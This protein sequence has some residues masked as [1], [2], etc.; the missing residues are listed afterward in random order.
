MGW[1]NL[2]LT[3]RTVPLG[4]FELSRIDVKLATATDVSSCDWVCIGCTSLFDS[5]IC[6]NVFSILKN[7]SSRCFF[8][9]NQRFWTTKNIQMKNIQS[10]QTF[11]LRNIIIEWRK[12][13][14][15]VPMQANSLPNLVLIW[16]INV[17]RLA[18]LCYLFENVDLST[19]C[20]SPNFSN[21]HHSICKM[22][23]GPLI[24]QRKNYK[25]NALALIRIKFDQNRI[26]IV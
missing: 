10:Y 24:L 15:H 3:V 2:I 6:P 9:M 19:N 18:E 5:S 20:V 22:E 1:C 23:S 16:S 12:G 17:Q 4:D 11:S 21:D 8:W 25:Q 26:F 7:S 13:V 14:L